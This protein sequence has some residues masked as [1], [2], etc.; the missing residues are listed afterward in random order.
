MERYLAQV[1]GYATIQRTHESGHTIK[2]E[3]TNKFENKTFIFSNLLIS[4][5]EMSPVGPPC[6]VDSIDNVCI[7]RRLE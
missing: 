5:R 4:K 3:D 1:R 6:G 2:R 7:H